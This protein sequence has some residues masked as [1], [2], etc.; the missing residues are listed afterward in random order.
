VP[1]GAQPANARPA[2]DTASTAGCSSPLWKVRTSGGDAPRSGCSWTGK[3]QDALPLL[4]SLAQD[5]ARSALG[6][7]HALWTL[8]GLGHL[9]SSLV[10]QALSDPE[11]GSARE[12]ARMADARL[13]K[14]AAL[15]AA[16]VDRRG[17]GADGGVQFQLLETLGFLHRRRCRGGAV[18]AA[19]RAHRRSS[20]CSAR[21]SQ[22]GPER[23]AQYLARAIAAGSTATASDTS[24]RRDFFFAT[25]VV[26]GARHDRDELHRAIGATVERPSASAAWWQASL[27]S[28]LHDGLGGAAAKAL[29]GE[30][31]LLVGLA[32]RSDPALRKA[33]L[34][35]LRATGAPADS[36][37]LGGGRTRRA[38]LDGSNCQW[39]PA[40][41]R[42]PAHGHRGCGVARDV[43]TGLRQSARAGGGAGCGARVAQSIKGVGIAQE[44]LPRWPELTPGARSALADLLLT[45]PDRQRL[46]VAALKDG[47]VQ[48]WALS[49]GQK[50][51]LIMNDDAGIR[52]D[53]RAI[54]EDTAEHRAAVVNRYAAAVE[55]GGDAMRGQQV[56]TKVCAACHHLGGGTSADVG[57]DLATVRH[58]PPLSLLVDILSPSQSI[59][60]GYETYVVKRTN[61]QTDAGTLAAQSAGSITL[62]QAGKT[63]VIPRREIKQLTVLG[64]STMPADLD[65]AISPEEMADL[66]AYV[67]KR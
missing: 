8:D 13:A 2:L 27:L 57:P 1:D 61:G 21:R 47:T 42:H 15:A 46:L 52:A 55:H 64:Q 25:G 54:L 29:E 33:A 11:P 67:T 49:F 3:H 63:V 4:T 5:R 23:A 45:S 12:R 22:R 9:D 44:V 48:P 16:V 56:F 39:C 26:I 50:R 28:G 17:Q 19:V 24:G 35:L 38:T 65:K 40:G 34:D 20:G 36:D 7:L 59:A 14:D 62:R 37:G 31:E 51:D 30:R 32:D 41:R 58:R 43:A 18:V 66:L 53:S 10:L 60:Q 6:R